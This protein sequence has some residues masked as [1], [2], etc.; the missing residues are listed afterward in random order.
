VSPS[1]SPP[2]RVAAIDWLRGLAVV[3]MIQAHGFDAW[4]APAAKTGDAYWFIRHMSGLP[5]RL[6]L[7]LVGVS[8]A[9][10]FNAQLAKGVDERTIRWQAAKRGLQIVGLA[11]L[12]RLQEYT[13]S[14]FKGGWQTLFKVD[15]LNAIGFSLLVVAAVA[16]PR[17]GR[18]PIAMTLVV[19]AVLLVLGPIVGPA[20]FPG[21]LPHV[22]TSYI[23]GQRPM[24]WFPVFPWGAWALVG[25]A[26]GQ[27]WVR[28]S[29]DARGE[30]RVFL[31][32]AL[33][34][35]ASTATII[36]IRAIDPFVIQ[37]QSEL[38]QQ[39]G[40]GSFFYRL[41]IIGVLAGLGW[42]VTRF[43]AGRFS[44]LSQ[45]GRTSLLI[46]WIHVDLCYG[47]ISRPLRG[48]LGVAGATAWI[49]ALVVLMLGVS[50]LKTRLTP[51]ASRWIAERLGRPAAQKSP[52]P[53]GLR[54]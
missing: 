3:L 17:R 38:A 48:K 5:S 6:F 31:L 19:A 12:F 9:I 47:G 43:T 8:A 7:L 15:I 36:G 40:P 51:P 25:V 45:L 52:L 30:R 49:L 26:V 35:V 39:M 37:Y 22:L 11:Y 42:A 10:R 32:T 16:A 28:Q 4:L 29:R 21:W 50:I 27:L 46:Y 41:G 23:G 54:T 53:S 18:I 20:H 2:S 24:S 44:P 34:G 33:A 1:V 14:G 13:L